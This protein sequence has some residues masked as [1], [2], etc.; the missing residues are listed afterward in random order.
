MQLAKPHA[1]AARLCQAWPVLLA[2]L[3]CE[4]DYVL[5]G[6]FHFLNFLPYLS[7]CYLGSGTMRCALAKTSLLPAPVIS[8]G[9][10]G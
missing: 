9:A 8:T 7:S 4:L 2:S 10:E 3:M 1:T 5:R 6:V